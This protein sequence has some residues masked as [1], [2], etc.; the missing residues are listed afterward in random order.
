MTIVTKNDQRILVECAILTGVSILFAVLMDKR[1]AR[2]KPAE[3]L[4]KGLSGDTL[5]VALEKA[6]PEEKAKAESARQA[7]DQATAQV[8]TLEKAERVAEKLEELAGSA[9]T[10]EVEQTRQPVMSARVSDKVAEKSQR[11]EQAVN[12]A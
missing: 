6:T 8:D 9:T 12:S 1:F 2:R 7:L 11:I 3:L 10:E 4:P 5:A